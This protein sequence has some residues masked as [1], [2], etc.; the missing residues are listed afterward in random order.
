M[1]LHE[2]YLF[3]QNMKML[4]AECYANFRNAL[5]SLYVWLGKNIFIMVS[6]IKVYVWWDGSAGKGP[7][8]WA[9]ST[10]VHSPEHRGREGLTPASYILTSAFVSWY[11]DAHMYIYT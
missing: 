10:W 9:L 6:K 3:C 1:K 8:H 11:T 2:I 5:W 7:H 4:D